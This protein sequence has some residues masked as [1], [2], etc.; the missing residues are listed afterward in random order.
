MINANKTGAMNPKI[1]VVTLIRNVLTITVWN[2]GLSKNCWKYL[3]P[4]NSPPVSPFVKSNSRNASWI[5]YIGM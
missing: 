1:S 2:I 3:K 4:T 5:P